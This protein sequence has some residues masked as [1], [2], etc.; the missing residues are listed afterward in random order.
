MN[1]QELKAQLQGYRLQIAML[2]KEAA[3]LET[4]IRIKQRQEIHDGTSVHTGDNQQSFTGER[5]PDDSR[6]DTQGAQHPE[7]QERGIGTADHADT[8]RTGQ[9]A[10]VEVCTTGTI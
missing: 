7:Q 8:A 1:S 3:R 9:P 6:G 4:L 5:H 2:T 10:P